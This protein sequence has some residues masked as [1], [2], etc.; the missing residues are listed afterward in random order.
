MYRVCL[1]NFPNRLY[2]YIFLS[3][4]FYIQREVEQENKFQTK[5]IIRSNY[6]TKQISEKIIK[7]L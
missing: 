6:Y 4:I 2:I 1:E 7:N 3:Y 5:S